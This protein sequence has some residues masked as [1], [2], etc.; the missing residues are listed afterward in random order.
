MP[1]DH[2]R[3]FR[4]APISPRNDGSSAF[5]PRNEVLRATKQIF[6]FASYTS[7]PFS[8][9]IHPSRAASRHNS[10]PRTERDV[11]I[12]KLG[13]SSVERALLLSRWNAVMYSAPGLR[14]IVFLRSFGMPHTHIRF[15][16][17]DEKMKMHNPIILC[18]RLLFLRLRI[19]VIT[20]LLFF[21]KKMNLTPWPGVLWRTFFLKN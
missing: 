19:T 4:F 10:S 14:C 20:I 16:K 12:W 2:V 15:C 3:I 21:T 6:Y 5:P 17:L 11:A 9:F 8:P 7:F 1:L 18:K 13:R